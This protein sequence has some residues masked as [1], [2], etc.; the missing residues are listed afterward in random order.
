VDVKQNIIDK[1]TGNVMFVESVLDKGDI[2][3]VFR[4]GLLKS[5]NSSPINKLLSDYEKNFGQSPEE[6]SNK[7]ISQ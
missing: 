2:P 5:D 7:G 6:R 1:R 4:T 3:K